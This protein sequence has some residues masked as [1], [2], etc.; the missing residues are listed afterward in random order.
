MAGQRKLVNGRRKVIS[1][2]SCNNLVVKA[3]VSAPRDILLSKFHKAVLKKCI[4]QDQ[5]FITEKS[6]QLLNQGNIA[7]ALQCGTWSFWYLRLMTTR[8][9]LFVFLRDQ[10]SQHF[11]EDLYFG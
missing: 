9:F 10:N 2:R 5:K 1:N 8:I 3:T 11:S 6:Y 4:F 7:D